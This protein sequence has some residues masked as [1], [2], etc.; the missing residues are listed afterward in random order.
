LI[1]KCWRIFATKAQRTC[2]TTSTRFEALR[3]K[4]IAEGII[5]DN[6]MSVESIYTDFAKH[7]LKV[8]PELRVLS[9]VLLRHRKCS[10]LRLPS[11][12][13]DWSQRCYGC[14]ILQRYYRF[15]SERLFKAGGSG[16]PQVDVEDLNVICLEGSC[17]D[18][19]RS[20][21]PIRSMWMDDEYKKLVIAESP[22]REL[23]SE[24]ISLDT[25][26]FTGEASWKA[27]LRTLTADRTALSLRIHEDHRA[28]FFSTFR[29]W[30]PNHL[31]DERLDDLPASAWPRYRRLSLQFSKSRI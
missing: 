24:A 25:Y 9:A 30:N 18:T 7:R 8:Q 20:I 10:D 26:P 17:L 19:E 16:K 5:I 22:L 14:G 13:A 29:E 21:F 23:T 2:E 12:V 6:Q 4:A 3:A 15:V 31:N 28:Q 1:L 27:F 11:W